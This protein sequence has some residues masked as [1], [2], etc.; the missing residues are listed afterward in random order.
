MLKR[1]AKSYIMVVL[2]VAFITRLG[3]ILYSP[4]LPA[5]DFS[6]YH[7]LATRISTGEGYAGTAG[8]TAFRPIGYPLL[9]SL[10]YFILGSSFRVGQIINVLL[11]TLTVYAT[12]ELVCRIFS[13]KAGLLASIFVALAPSL[14]MYTAVLA[15]EN[16]ATAFG[17]MCVLMI[18]HAFN[19]GSWIYLLPAGASLGLAILARPGFLFYPAMF[20]F[21]AVLTRHL[22][23]RTMSYTLAFSA[24]T[25]LTIAPWT[26]RNYMVFGEVIPVATNG[27]FNLA[28]SFNEGSTGEYIGGIT[29]RVLGYSYDWEAYRLVGVDWTEPQI[30]AALSSA[31]KDF[32]RDQPLKAFML[33]PS[34]LRFFLQ[35]DVSGVFE[36]ISR[37][38]RETP[39]WLWSTL[40]I[41]AQVYYIGAL[42]LAMIG[43]RVGLFQKKHPQSILLLLSILYWCALHSVF[44]GTDRFHL[45]ILPFI[46]AFSSVGCLYLFERYPRKA[47]G[48]VFYQRLS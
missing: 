11:G 5:Q 17:L 7:L 40:R 39:A 29:E 37:P 47:K 25:L 1:G 46:F 44:L 43:I 12:Y 18:Y 23:T 16:M 38:A 27:G 26:Y 8:P 34:K 31:A 33:T 24:I 3:W 36:N 10:G 6:A 32:I 15:S 42:V 28:I 41:L 22:L 21:Y 35:D 9:L 48:Q 13:K 20:F 30:D 45:P 4:A 2:A 19:K 14:I